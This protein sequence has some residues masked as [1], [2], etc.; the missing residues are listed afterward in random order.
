M[1]DDFLTSARR[2]KA[3]VSLIAV[4][5]PNWLDAPLFPECYGSIGE[6]STISALGYVDFTGTVGCREMW[7]QFADLSQIQKQLELGVASLPDS[8]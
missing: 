2:L 6:V 7:L 4:F 3:I 8:G 1:R 5:K